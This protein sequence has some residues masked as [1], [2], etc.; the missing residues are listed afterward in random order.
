[1]NVKSRN[2]LNSSMCLKDL[3][4]FPIGVQ[5][6]E[7]KYMVIK[8]Y[9]KVKRKEFHTKINN[10]RSFLITETKVTKT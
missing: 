7:W 9:S 5:I 1:M 2:I 10:G 8:H 4:D 3:S 6:R